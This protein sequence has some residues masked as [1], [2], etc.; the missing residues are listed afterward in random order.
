MKLPSPKQVSRRGR[1]KGCRLVPRAGPSLLAPLSCADATWLQRQWSENDCTL[2]WR[3]MWRVHNTLC[4]LLVALHWLA[5]SWRHCACHLRCS[6]IT[7]PCLQSVLR[8]S[9]NRSGLI[10]HDAERSHDRI[11]GETCRVFWRPC[12]PEAHTKRMR[13]FSE[14][15][16]MV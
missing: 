2:R 1:W 9:S 16:S 5:T 6:I 8:F 10:R 7:P 15:G 13:L 3:L 4:V 14:P 11:H 12:V